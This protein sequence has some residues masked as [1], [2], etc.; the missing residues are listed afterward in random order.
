[1]KAVRRFAKQVLKRLPDEGS[2]IKSMIRSLMRRKEIVLGDLARRMGPHMPN[3]YE[4]YW[5]NPARIDMHTNRRT[6]SSNWEEWVFDQ[7]KRISLVQDGDWDQ[8]SHKVEE[9]RAF[10]AIADRIHRGVSWHVTDYYKSAVSKIEKGRELWGC[11]DRSGFDEHCS[12]ID[13]L[14]DSI[15]S[16]GYHENNANFGYSEVLINISRHGDCL[17]QDGR[18]R[19][20]IVRALGIKRIPVQIYVRHAKWQSFREFMHRMARGDG[21]ASKAGVLYQSPI[22]FDL[23]DISHEHACDDRWD[24]VKENLPTGTGRALDIGCNL[25]FFCHRLEDEGYSCVGVEYLPDIAHAAQMIARAENRRLKIV[26]GDILDP[27]ILK[28][29]GGNGFEVV[30]ALNIFH[31]FIK[32]HEG[33]D[34]L[35][36]LLGRL[37]AKTMFFESHLPDEQQMVGAFT[38]PGP[39]EFVEL[40]KQWGGFDE[41]KAIYTA[42]DGRT[43]FCLSRGSV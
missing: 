6:I 34:K 20:A 9:M 4:R 42:S 24:A 22:H 25:G 30:I 28:E 21:G 1:M 36:Q 31:H 5:L 12:K 43:V 15:S 3:P 19:L 41:A 16:S 7:R 38:N 33:F 35:Q 10:R 11:H 39:M 40:I 14:I 29:V 32:T 2:L 27:E 37:R 26:T 8:P 18:H 23:G 17:F 13:R